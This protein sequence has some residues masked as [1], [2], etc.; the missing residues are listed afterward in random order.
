RGDG[1][2]F[3]AADQFTDDLLGTERLHRVQVLRAQR[4]REPLHHVGRRRVEAGERL[5]AV[6]T[7]ARASQRRLHR[8]DAGLQDAGGLRQRQIEDVFEQKPRAFLPLH[9]PPQPAPPP[10]PPPRLHPH[11]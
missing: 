9:P 10:P 3:G 7:S 1:G 2:G 5:P 8:A 6:Q 4:R 11:R